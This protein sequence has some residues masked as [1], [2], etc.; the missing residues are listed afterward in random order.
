MSVNGLL[1][2]LLTIRE[3]SWREKK[4]AWK[5]LRNVSWLSR[6]ETVFLKNC[7]NKEK[8]LLSFQTL[9]S[10]VWQLKDVELIDS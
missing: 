4:C 5:V 8:K 1:I 7:V 2:R 10:V 9:C 3:D 6:A